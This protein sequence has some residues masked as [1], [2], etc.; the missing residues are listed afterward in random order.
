MVRLSPLDATLSELSG[1][2][3][4]QRTCSNAKFFI[5]NTYR[6]RKGPCSSFDSEF[7]NACQYSLAVSLLFPAQPPSL[8]PNA[9]SPPLQCLQLNSS[10]PIKLGMHLVTH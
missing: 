1:I 4:I 5:C 9:T 8:C 2:C 3:C 6:N 7:A 10:Y